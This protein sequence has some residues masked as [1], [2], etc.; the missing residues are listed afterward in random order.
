[1]MLLAA[2]ANDHARESFTRAL[3]L[4]PHD[5]ATLQGYVRASV[6]AGREDEVLSSLQRIVST[7]PGNVRARIE[8]SRLLAGRRQFTN[9]VQMLGEP[10]AILDASAR[11][12]LLEQAAS[13]FAD[14]SDVVGLAW[15]T[16]AL[17]QEADGQDLA[18]FYGATTAYLQGR[19]EEAATLAE[20]ASDHLPEARVYNLLGVTQAQL[21]RTTIARR[22]FMN[23]LA[24]DPND[25]AAHVNLGLLELEVSD[26]RAAAARFLEALAINPAVPAAREGLAVSLE[27]LEQPERAARIRRAGTG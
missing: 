13:V 21:G 17:G 22:A 2:G 19:V 26:P 25:T 1:M 11:T 15:A 9:A 8:A 3:E 24:V 10:T 5:A 12:Q 20:R 18:A 7:G 23:A 16:S 6:R 27:H 14:A 4:D